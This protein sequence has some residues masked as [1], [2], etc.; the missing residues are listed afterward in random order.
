M[1]HVSGRGVVSP[2]KG[3]VPVGAVVGDAGGPGAAGAYGYA[4]T[5]VHHAAAN[6]VLKGKRGAQCVYYENAVAAGF[7]VHMAHGVAHHVGS[8]G[9]VQ[10]QVDTVAEAGGIVGV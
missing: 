10:F 6:A 3:G 8:V 4:G 1:G 7:A 5:G 2:A 9:Y